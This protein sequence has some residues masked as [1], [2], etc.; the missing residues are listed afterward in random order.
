[1]LPPTDFVASLPPPAERR[2]A[3]RVTR[4]AQQALRQGHPW[5]FDRSITS[6]SAAGRAGDLAVIFDDRRRFLAI[7]LYD[8]ESPI[9]VRVLQHGTPATIDAAFFARRLAEATALRTPLVSTDTNGYRLVNGEGDHLPGLAIDRYD[10]VL[11]MK[12]YS[13]AWLP[14][15]PM[16]LDGLAALAPA[17]WIVLR[18]SRA[19]QDAAG[20]LG[21][22]DGAT[23]AGAPPDGVPCFLENG[24]TFEVDVLKGQKTG[25][26]LDQRENRARV[27]TLA[28]GKETL[29]VFAYTGGFSLYA[30]R[31]GAPLVVSL[32]ISGPALDAARRNFELNDQ[33]PAVAGARREFL[34]EDAFAGLARLAREGRRFDLVVVD[35]PAFAQQQAAIP[36]ALLAYERL[37]KLALGVLRKGGTLVSASCSSRVSAEA[38]YDAVRRGAAG[39]G[40]SLKEFAH[41]GHALDHPVLFAEGAYLKCMYAEVDDVW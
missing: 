11:V 15:V 1:M 39:A 22:A 37:T 19:V 41:T 7:G 30:A 9:R 4:A 28:A 14:F 2:I 18:L 17:D 6:Q 16:V 26:F 24:L 23:L 33:A 38:F 13:A 40:C 21:I 29:N 8:P 5:L 35:P 31:G 36:N 34:V 10:R 25:F 27:E 20:P 12:L 32:D 3:L